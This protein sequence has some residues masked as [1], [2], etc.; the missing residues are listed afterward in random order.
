M[1]H[2]N[3]RHTLLSVFML[4]LFVCYQAGITVCVHSHIIGGSVVAHSHPYGGKTHTHSGAEFVAIH[5]LST[6]QCDDVAQEN[7]LTVYREIIDEYDCSL[8][9]NFHISGAGLT[10]CLRAPPSFC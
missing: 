10:I 8:K 1:E 2:I 9:E 4:V 6:F 3:R 7:N 5:S